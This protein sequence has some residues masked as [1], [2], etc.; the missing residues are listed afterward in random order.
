MTAPHLAR[1][2]LERLRRV[3]AATPAKLLVEFRRLLAN[4]AKAKGETR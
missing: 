4:E 1:L 3:P 2:L